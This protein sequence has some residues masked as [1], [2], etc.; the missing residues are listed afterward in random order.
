MIGLSISF[1]F[2][3]FLCSLLT[4]KRIIWIM[5]YHLPKTSFLGKLIPQYTL[6]ARLLE[7]V[8]IVHFTSCLHGGG[9]G[10]QEHQY[11]AGV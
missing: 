11:T 10:E 9:T 2:Q 8:S 5:D 3:A 6:F 7:P 1:N 4:G